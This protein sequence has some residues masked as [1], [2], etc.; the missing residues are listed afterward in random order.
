MCFPLRR[1]KVNKP[2]KDQQNVG[3]PSVCSSYYPDPTESTESQS[4]F[5]RRISTPLLCANKNSSVD[6]FKPGSMGYFGK[7]RD[8][9]N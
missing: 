1:Y 8:S 7:A 5:R 4:M 2:V 6:F 3:L 9:T